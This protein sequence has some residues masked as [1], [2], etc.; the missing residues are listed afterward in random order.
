MKTILK[1]AAFVLLIGLLS[2]LSCKK[3]TSCEGC[4]TKNN[5]PPIAIAGP[6]RAITLPTDSISLD[7]N[8]SKDPDGKISEWLWTK[9]SGPA[10]FTIIKPTDSTTKVKA[11]VTGTYQFELKVKDNGGLS[12]KDTI[13]I[14][15]NDPSLPN[16]PPVANAGPDQTITLSTNS[17]NLDGSSS[18]DPD[19][20]ITNYLWTKISGTASFNITNTNNVQTQVTN[21]I[22][23]IYQFELKVTDASG[24][25]SKDTMLVTV[26]NTTLPDPCAINRPI[27]N[28][29]LIPIGTLSQA[30]EAVAIASAGNKI[31]FAGGRISYWSTGGDATS[32]VDI[33]DIITQSWS[34]AEL[35]VPRMDIVAV[36]AG[37]KIF[38]AGGGNVSST[39]GEVYSTVDIYD[40]VT[41]TWSVSSLS[42][43]GHFTTATVGNKVFFTGGNGVNNG[44]SGTVDIYDL[45]TNIW[46]TATLS[47][48]R[49]NMSAVT[50][51]NQIY[52]A[53]GRIPIP[54]SD[55]TEDY[56]N[57]IDIYDNAT[58]SWSVSVLT[59]PKWVMGSIAVNNKIYWAG[60]LGYSG[61]NRIVEK[62]D[63]I[64]QT[65]SFDCLSQPKAPF[66]VVEKDNK[67]VFF[68]NSWNWGVGFNNWFDLYDITSNT[69]SVGIMNQELFRASIISVNNNIYLA[70]ATYPQTSGPPKFSNQVWKLEF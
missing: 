66:H 43:K 7:G 33:Y 46:S 65:T 54:G 51:N 19:N 70:G 17:V 21:L 45:S 68:T 6:D 1:L 49:W 69:W 12:A 10:S 31:L 61:I 27:I 23:G 11:L 42:E 39:F 5:K 36:A 37:N 9:I 63:V 22:Q 4:A 8:A 52:F 3:E 64:A 53:G 35:S 15:V 20:N 47:E 29:R 2:H 62:K 34:T 41:N 38:F 18:T 60:G 58:S 59:E 56:S 57:R 28:A 50:A 55:T 40:V 13:Q 48:A 16:R 30:R 25:F 44:P 24:L 14:T 26:N 67:I 32:R